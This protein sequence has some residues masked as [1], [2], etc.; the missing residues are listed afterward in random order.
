MTSPA[1]D[2]ECGECTAFPLD[3][4]ELDELHATATVRHPG[5]DEAEADYS[6][7]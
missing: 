3:V 7:P 6:S 4:D 2:P 1:L 5:A